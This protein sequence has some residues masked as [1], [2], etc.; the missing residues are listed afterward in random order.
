MKTY[1]LASDIKSHQYVGKEVIIRG[2][3]HRL[4]KQ[5]ENTFILVRDHRGGVIQSVF[6]STT[7][8]YLNIESSVEIAGI[9]HQDPR[10][11]EGGYEI[12]GEYIKS[13]VEL[14]FAQQNLERNKNLF[15]NNISPKKSLLLAQA[16]YEKA[17]AEY[18]SASEKLSSIGL[19]D[20]EVYGVSGNENLPIID[21]RAP[22]SGKIVE[23][24][25]TVGEYIES[26]KNL[27]KIIDISKFW[28]DAVVYEKD[29]SKIKLG[30]KVEIIV[31]AYPDNVY[32]GEIIYI[33]DVINGETKTL[34]IRT[35]VN[36]PKNILKPNMFSTVKIYYGEGIK[37]L[38][39]ASSAIESDNDE[40]FVFVEEENN[41]FVKRNV[42]CGIES[43]GYMEIISGLKE[44]EN[45]VVRGSFALKSELEK[46]KFVSSD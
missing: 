24:N 9:L 23:R 7:V 39:I 21:I 12:K 19:T 14:E 2:W 42:K 10:A 22:I 15:E 45:V 37:L 27:F 13:K 5:K 26:T 8:S 3:V 41:H 38:A 29:I 33:G 46:S 43:D 17:E 6:P 18:L 30:Q 4:R 31:N 1:T 34:T 16:E 35:I 28:V 25:I 20:K 11:P 36:N 32:N 44:G 40:T